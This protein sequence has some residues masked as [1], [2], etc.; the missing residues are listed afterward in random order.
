MG[1]KAAK[2]LAQAKANPVGVRFADLIR[3]VEAAGFVLDRQN[4]SH[5]VYRRAGLAARINV[6]PQGS[7]AKAYQVRQV[8]SI[9]ET[10]NLEVS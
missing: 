9:I 3:L 5:R 6:Q 10:H 2:I 8:V 1:S 7:M 4:G